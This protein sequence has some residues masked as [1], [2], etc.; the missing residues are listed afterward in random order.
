M[1]VSIKMFKISYFSFFFKF[2]EKKKVLLKYG[3]ERGLTSKFL[4]EGGIW[5]LIGVWKI[6]KE[7]RGLDK[8]RVEK[9]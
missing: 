3:L 4:L 1:L 7:K 5:C 6:F 8:K 9:K 2:N